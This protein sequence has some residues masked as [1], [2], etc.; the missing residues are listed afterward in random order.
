L[1][2]KNI[3][4]CTALHWSA[5]TGRTETADLLLSQ[6][7]DIDSRTQDGQTIVHIAASRGHLQYLR[8][9]AERGATL[10]ATTAAGWSG[11]HFSV[12]GNYPKVCEFLIASGV[13]P[14]V[15]DAKKATVLALAEKY[16]RQWFEKLLEP[17]LAPAPPPATPPEQSEE[18]EE[19]EDLSERQPAAPAVDEENVP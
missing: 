4:G 16:K 11:I 8:Y 19:G 15:L 14:H 13:D 3:M 1:T 7:A 18:E 12:V 10:T 17:P 9:V 5:F 6:G 2:K